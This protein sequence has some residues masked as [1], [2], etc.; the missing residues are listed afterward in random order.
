LGENV[1][2]YCENVNKDAKSFCTQDVT[3]ITGQKMNTYNAEK[4]I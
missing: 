3:T 1:K 4:M 2:Y